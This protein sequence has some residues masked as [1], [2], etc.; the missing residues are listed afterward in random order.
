MWLTRKPLWLDHDWFTEQLHW[1]TD[2]AEPWGR[3]LGTIRLWQNT[4]LVQKS[5]IFA[6]GREGRRKRC[7]GLKER[8][9]SSFAGAALTKYHKMKGRG[10][11][12]NR[13]FLPHSCRGQKSE[14]QVSARPCP[15]GRCCEG[16]ALGL[17]P[18]F[19]WFLV[20]WQC[21]SSL[22]GVPSL[23][24]ECAHTLP[25]SVSTSLLIRTPVV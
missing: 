22:W 1:V 2:C 11:L 13:N 3:A 12:N 14:T 4:H 10:S 18:S 8:V 23:P 19:R 7:C 9:P 17:S 6:T 24:G 25:V 15:L 20:S 16:S 21:N 5:F